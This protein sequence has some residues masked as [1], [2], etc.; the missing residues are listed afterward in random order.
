M[1]RDIDGQSR[2]KRRAGT[3]TKVIPGGPQFKPPQYRYPRRSKY[4]PRKSV[5]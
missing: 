5:S 3:K 2:T 4:H 1:K